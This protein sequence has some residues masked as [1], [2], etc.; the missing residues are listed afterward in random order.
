MSVK[1]IVNLKTVVSNAKRVKRLLPPEVKFC[2][3]VKADAYGHGAQKVANALYKMADCFA[4]AT[5]EEGVALRL[6]GIDK[7]VLVLTRTL[8]GELARAVNYGLTLTACALSDLK[9]YA[10]EGGRQ[11]ER[12]KVHIKYDTGMRR[13]GISDFAELKAALLYGVKNGR[14]D[15]CGLYSH[16]ACPENE[17][18]HKRAMRK[19]SFA[20][21]LAKKFDE[22][23]VCHISA[24]GGFIA[25]EFCD[26]VRIGILL[27]GYTPFKTDVIQVKPAMKVFAPVVAE[28][29]LM[30]GDCALYGE[31][32]AAK[33]VR[34]TLVRYGYADGLPRK[35]TVGQFNNRCMDI[36][37]LTG[38][39]RGTKRV[40]VMDNAEEIA[41]R[42]DTIPY[43]ILVKCALRADK[44]YIT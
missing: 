11:D 35:E 18:S 9:R 10:R 19:F 43:E 25:G 29:T 3:V 17:N 38:V 27:Y 20:K 12:V 32:R 13:Q 40:A 21:S 7:D 15:L 1:A 30:R 44:I 36:T 33:S 39:K 22:N 5:V 28:K 37:A 26:M 23:I 8:G 41:E 31:K 14:I 16:F 6:C 2:A 4:V 42:Y 34:I 24:S